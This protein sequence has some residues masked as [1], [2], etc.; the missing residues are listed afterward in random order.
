MK[1]TIVTFLA[2]C[3]TS[4][5][6]FDVNIDMGSGIYYTAT[7]GK[8]VYTKDFWKGSSGDMD[9]NT[10]STPYIWMEVAPSLNYLPKLRLE[11][12]QLKTAGSSAIAIKTSNETINDLLKLIEDQIGINIS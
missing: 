4:L 8:L 3:F 10:A 1:K 2:L 6:A 9:H 7:D 11:L 12:S 5:H